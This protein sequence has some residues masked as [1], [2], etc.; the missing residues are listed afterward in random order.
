VKVQNEN[1]VTETL[2]CGN[3]IKSVAFVKSL[4]CTD[5]ERL[6]IIIVKKTC[7]IHMNMTFAHLLSG[8]KKTNSSKVIKIKYT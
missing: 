6:S 1:I 7:F 5:V 4:S 3:S 8:I 2:N